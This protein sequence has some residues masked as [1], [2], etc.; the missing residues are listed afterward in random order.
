MTAFTLT[1][2]VAIGVH[3]RAGAWAF[4]LMLVQLDFRWARL[5]PTWVA[6]TSLAWQLHGH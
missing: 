2:F 1:N 4:G 5:W 6:H 3:G